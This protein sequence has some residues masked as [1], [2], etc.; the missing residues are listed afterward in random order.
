MKNDV[1]FIIVIIDFIYTK[2]EGSLAISHI[3]IS[4]LLYIKYCL[5][6]NLFSVKV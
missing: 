5:K 2:M 6:I 4:T 3:L 1:I